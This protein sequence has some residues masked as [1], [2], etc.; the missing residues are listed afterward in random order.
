ME[1]LGLGLGLGFGLG[2][3]FGL[4]LGLGPGLGPI[5]DDAAA[6]RRRLGRARRHHRGHART[7]GEQ[8]VRDGV[9]GH[10]E[11]GAARVRVERAAVHRRVGCPA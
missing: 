2:L 4:G 6:A 10:V 8:R 7:G 1:A 9:H 11:A 3:R 5:D